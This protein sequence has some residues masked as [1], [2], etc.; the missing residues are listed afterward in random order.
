MAVDSAGQGGKEATMSE[1]WRKDMG[2]YS[3]LALGFALAGSSVLPGKALADLPVFFATAAGAGIALLVLLP[4][5]AFEGRSVP[6]RRGTPWRERPLWKA[7]PLWRA[8][9]LLALQAFFGMA[10][11][12]VL[13]LAALSRTGAAEVGMA[14]SAAPAITAL[15]A[16]LFLKERIGPNKAAGIALVVAG[17]A[18]LDS[19]GG[20]SQAGAA[21]EAASA[22]DGRLAGLCLA[23]GAAASESIFNVIAKR[24][25]SE[26]GPMRSSA[27]VT[28]IAFAMLAALSLATGEVVDIALAL[29]THLPAF[30]YQ[31]VFVSAIAYVFFYRGAARLPASTIGLFSCMMPL[32]GFGLS[33]ILLGE[34]PGAAGILG[35]ALALFGIGL[36][37]R[38]PR[39]EG[40]AA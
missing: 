21:G 15:P 4:L 14:M 39:R 9:P 37:A 35:A 2:V 17:I 26:L 5:A 31:G 32:A 18:L 1:G 38:M 36:C 25:P 24:L 27:A 23:V 10:L 20:A 34:R 22:I 11:F 28:A 16:A 40:A 19:G 29:R 7:R 6:R 8:I 3:S 33:V 13:M 12:R 30:A